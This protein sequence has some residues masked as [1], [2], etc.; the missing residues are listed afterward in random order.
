MRGGEYYECD[1]KAMIEKVMNNGNVVYEKEF[2]C[3]DGKYYMFQKREAN[4]DGSTFTYTEYYPSGKISK[5]YGMTFNLNKLGPYMDYYENGNV[6]ESGNY[7]KTEN[8]NSVMDGHFYSIG[9]KK[10]TLYSVWFDNNYPVMGRFYYENGKL[11]DYIKL[12]DDNE[13]QIVR[14]YDD[15]GTL[16]RS[17][18][19]RA[20]PVSKECPDG[21]EVLNRKDPISKSGSCERNIYNPYD[22]NADLNRDNSEIFLEIDSIFENGT[23]KS[24]DVQLPYQYENDFGKT[25]NSVVSAN[26]K[27][28]IDDQNNITAKRNLFYKKSLD[29]VKD[30]RSKF[31]VNNAVVKKNIYNA[32]NKILKDYLYGDHYVME[33]RFTRTDDTRL[34][35]PGYKYSHFLKP[36]TLYY[37][38]YLSL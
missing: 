37:T 25:I 35:T 34:G 12:T 24:V 2:S 29:V 6:K 36:I 31:F 10:D 7:I 17:S 27:K 22:L 4:K 38:D 16:E 18:I 26:I 21:T 11:K 19:F 1:G 9:E 14:H 3:L 5:K 33:G 23:L 28:E 30:I 13:S 8:Y 32:I 15:K 20:F